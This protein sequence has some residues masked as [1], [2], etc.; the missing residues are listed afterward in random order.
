VHESVLNFVELVL[1]AEDVAG[2]RVLEVGSYDVNGSVR[3]YIESLEPSQYLGVDASAGPRV[4]QVVDCMRLCDEVGY[5]WDLVV[6]TEMLEHVRDW[7]GC[8]WQLASAVKPNGML[9]VTTR[10][11]GFKYHP[12]PEDHWRY[13]RVAMKEILDALHLEREALEDDPQAPGVFVL[14]RKGPQWEPSLELLAGIAVEPVN[15]R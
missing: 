14:A 4:D 10:S 1:T 5:G 11:P 12:Y 2:K 9:L 6:S 13:T 15:V 7:R 8:M 3:P